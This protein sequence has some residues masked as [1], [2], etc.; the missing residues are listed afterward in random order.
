[1]KNYFLLLLTFIFINAN[2]QVKVGDAA[3]DFKLKNVDGTYY[4]LKNDKEAKGFVVIFTCNHC[5]FSQAYEQ[6][7]IELDKKYK[8]LG[9]PVIAINPNDPIKVPED[10]YEEMVKRAKE[11]Q[12]TFP[13]LHDE[14]QQT[15][16]SYGA[17]R[18]PHVFIVVKGKD[19]SY[20]V[21]YIGA[22]DND[23]ENENKDKTKYVENALE[24]LLKGKEPKVKET[25]A[26]GCSIKWKA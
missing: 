23:T 26:I 19:N 20:K 17:A 6:R 8:K 21:A 2:A 4:S 5:P 24:E 9:Y 12:Y 10:S 14:T 25:K 22:I 15:A 7:I 13:Y 3:K 11:Y 18:T 16:K 1:M